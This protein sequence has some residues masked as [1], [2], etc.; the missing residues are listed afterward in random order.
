[1]PK[2]IKI[3]AVIKEKL[4]F[5]APLTEHIAG[6]KTVYI[7]FAGIAAF[8]LSIIAIQAAIFNMSYD[9]AF[10][11]VAYS[12]YDRFFDMFVVTLANNHFLNSFLIYFTALP[13]PFNSF[14]IR[15]PA[16]IFCIIYFILSAIIS[17]KFKNS[18]LCFGLLT[19]NYFFIHH[20]SVARGYGMAATLV[21]AGLS[22]LISEKNKDKNN[23]TAIVLLIIACVANFASFSILIALITYLWFFEY[24]RKLLVFSKRRNIFI[25][26]SVTLIAIIFLNLSK[27]GKPLFGAYNE[28]FTQA[29]TLYYLQTLIPSVQFSILFVYVLE[30]L[31][32]IYL[33]FM[34]IKF[35][36]KI[37]FGFILAINFLII[38]LSSKLLHK[39]YPTARVL[40]PYW[41][42]LVLTAIECVEILTNKLSVSKY[43]ITS[44]N[45]LCLVCLLCFYGAQ[46]TFKKNIFTNSEE[47][48]METDVITN[49]NIADNID[50]DIRPDIEFYL[51]KGKF[52]N[53]IPA[54]IN[55]LTP[56][57][58]IKTKNEIVEFYKQ[59][60]I[61]SLYSKQN[62]ENDF[63][64]YNLVMNNDSVISKSINR[65]LFEYDIKDSICQLII[66]PNQINE[67]KRIDILNNK[68][69]IVSLNLNSK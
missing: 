17:T 4:N 57:T 52:Y 12:K 31:F 35:P 33:V 21:L 30:S 9:E 49:L 36:Q 66:L 29:V 53:T 15:L 39:P 20:F 48:S 56:D 19:C 68:K 45:V 26:V 3:G 43:V 40:V 18:L 54:N 23:Y 1:M 62:V 42:L 27:D 25:A 37:K 13:A 47:I 60:K 64:T 58:L 11:Y 2:K 41:P 16:F 50:K 46:I 44:F 22:F 51:R 67:F 59:K 55:K 32:V 24:K 14:A 69:L 10:T 38:Y 7:L 34:L 28:S 8:I 65:D 61:I 6:K 5:F 63:Y